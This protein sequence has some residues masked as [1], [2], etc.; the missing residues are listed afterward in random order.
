MKFLYA[1][2]LPFIPMAALEV[3]P[4]FGD[5]YEFHFLGS[6]AYSRFSSFQ[7]A[8]PPFNAIFGST[9]SSAIRSVLPR[10]QALGSPPLRASGILAVRPM[11]TSISRSTSLSARSSRHRIA[12][13]SGPGVSAPSAMR[14]GALPGF[15][16][17]SQWRPTS[18]ISTNGL[19]MRLASMGMG[20]MSMS[21]RSISTA[22]RKCGRRRSISGSGMAT[23]SVFGGRSASSTCAEFLR[24]RRLSGSTPSSSATSCLSLFRI[25]P[26]GRRRWRSRSNG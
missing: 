6:F 8:V 19:S 26:R 22:M 24:N 3:Q 12:G 13:F 17:S 15:A 4:W 14:I 2:L 7:D 1:L 9:T 18:T 20:A 21:T 11:G 25:I 23:G 10:G 16:G 5:V